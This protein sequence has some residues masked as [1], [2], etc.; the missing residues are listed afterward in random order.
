MRASVIH[1]HGFSPH[2]RDMERPER[3]VGRLGRED[4]V[5][6]TYIAGL[7]CGAPGVR[8]ATDFDTQIHTG[9]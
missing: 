2:V 6:L 8:V 7:L 3:G 4:A 5:E 1:L 9:N